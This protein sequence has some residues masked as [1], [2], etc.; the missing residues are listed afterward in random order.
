[1]G[2]TENFHALLRRGIAEREIELG[3]NHWVLNRRGSPVYRGSDNGIPSFLITAIVIYSF[4]IGG[5]V[6]G[7]VAL[8]AGIVI[9]VTLVRA[10]VMYRLRVRTLGL[11]MSSVE[12]WEAFWDA[13]ALSLRLRQDPAEVCYSPHDDWKDFARRHLIRRSFDGPQRRG[14]TSLSR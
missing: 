3:Y 5:L 14:E 8:L 1:M 9:F 4:W 13:G 11:A 6:W 2:S 12:A 7:F 10:F